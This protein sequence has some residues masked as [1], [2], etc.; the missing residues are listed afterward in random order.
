MNEEI[1]LAATERAR[2]RGRMGGGPPLGMVVTL[3]ECMASFVARQRG[4]LTE[5]T[6]FLRTIAGAEANL[7]VGLARL[8]IGVSYIG[9]V[10]DDALGRTIQRRLRGEGVDVRHL[11]VDVQATTGIMI[12]EVRDL[13]PAEVIYWRAGSAGSRLRGDDVEAAA[14]TIAAARW[15]HV[16]GITP[17]LS[18]GAAAAVDMAVERARAAG[19]TV[20][21]DINLRRRLWSESAARAALEP[22]AARCD[23]VL[24][25]LDE[26]AVI[27][28]LAET[29]EAAAA[30]EPEAA[31]EA[32]LA[33]GP[34]VAVV[35]LG[36]DGALE[37]RRGEAGVQTSSAAAFRV[38]HVVDPVGAGDAFAAG[39]IATSLEGG[40]SAAALAAGNACGAAVVATLGDQSGLPTRVELDRLLSDAPGDTIR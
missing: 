33:L 17:A 1:R 26:M 3:G 14:G 8:G 13:G 40:T 15:L 34:E 27:G 35:K 12:R 4:P 29:L 6:D 36:A 19:A 39:Y 9:R 24:G 11:G 20:S 37:Q 16:T 21:L 28:G 25:G 2:R 5:A 30:V 23:V 10:G 32:I 7:A 18:P 38:P 31:A 22:L